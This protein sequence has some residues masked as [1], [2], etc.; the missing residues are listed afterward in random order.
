M[1]KLVQM[2]VVLVL[3]SPALAAVSGFN[4]Q[5]RLTDA[6]GI[7]RDGVFSLKFGVFDAASGGT[8]RWEKALPSVTVRN[9]NFQ[10]VLQDP[11][12]GGTSG[13]LE[14]AVS[15]S[16]AFLEIQVGSE[17]PLVPRQKLASAPSALIVQGGAGGNVFKAS[18]NV[19]IGT[20][21]PVEK[22]TVAGNVKADGSI[23]STFGGFRFPDGSVLLSAADA[24]GKVVNVT[25]KKSNVRVVMSPFNSFVVES[26]M[27][28]KKSP[29]SALFI[30][31]TVSLMVW[32]D[33][34]RAMTQGW[35][36]GS[37]VE[38]VAQGYIYTPAGG[39]SVM[40]TQ[41]VIS[42]HTTTGPQTMVY[43]W[44]AQWADV[45]NPIK[46]YNPNTADDGRLG[47]TQ[48]IYTVWEIEEPTLVQ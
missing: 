22:L 46:I 7:N 33:P 43:R 35:K 15:V 13:S 29:T 5:G 12:E 38:Q 17:A 40:P 21:S 6:G 25:A 32:S 34:A 16:D 19:G 24:T 28:D 42:G 44:Y 1:T 31:G 45:T 20:T 9:G 18:G 14:D 26:F 3:S 30:Q 8:L 48:S 4:I 47:Q 10:V 41:A 36:F 11:P 39:L 27:V 2:A 23:H 37:G